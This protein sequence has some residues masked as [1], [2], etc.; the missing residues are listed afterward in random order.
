MMLLSIITIHLLSI[1]LVSAGEPEHLPTFWDE[2]PSSISDYSRT[3]NCSSSQ[4]RTNESE[5]YLIDPWLYVDRLGMY[6]ILINVTTPF[7]RFC[8]QSTSTT[9][10]ILFGLAAQLGWQF[11]S[12]RLF[13]NGTKNISVNSWWASWNYYVSVI[14][15]LA[16]ADTGFIRQGTF[17]IVRRDAFCSNSDEC[18]I[19][20]PD[21]MIQWRNFFINLIQSV[22]CW[23]C[24][25]CEIRDECYLAAFWSAHTSSIDSSLSIID[26]KLPLLPSHNEQQ[27]GLSWV[28]AMVLI[29]MARTVSD[30]DRT[31][32]YQSLYLPNRTLTKD[33]KPPNCPDLSD[34][35]NLALKLLL[36]VPIELYPQLRNQWSQ[37]T[38]FCYEQ[39][40]YAQK[41]LEIVPISKVMALAF[42]ELALVSP[43]AC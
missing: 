30:L 23:V 39:D 10:N 26:T 25:I 15:F 12:N 29:G 42:Y 20:V 34:T 14:P 7:M 22:S 17:R 13:S 35:V 4:I 5:C 19:Q 1:S 3:T 2:A 24:S 6:K 11:D 27:F 40:Q 8:S 36:E 31:N 33:D 37:A 28:N 9:C 21:A 32:N 16:A 43:L 38:G 41:A 18:S